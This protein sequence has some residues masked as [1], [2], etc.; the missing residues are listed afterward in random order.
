MI[1]KPYGV[2]HGLKRFLLA[3]EQNNLR[4]MRHAPTVETEQ[5]E[6]EVRVGPRQV[7]D[8]AM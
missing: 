7:L 5:P 4:K 8:L 6:R 3:I 2:G 1:E